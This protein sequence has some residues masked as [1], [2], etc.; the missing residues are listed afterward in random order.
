MKIWYILF[1]AV[2]STFIFTAC[3]KNDDGF[4]N[5]FGTRCDAPDSN[6]IIICKNEF[7]PGSL[8]VRKG[9]TITWRNKDGVIHTVVADN[10]I[11]FNSGNI[12]ASGSYLYHTEFTGTFNY[13]CSIHQETGVLVVSP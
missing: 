4:G 8:S 7:I 1:I 13:H 3:T 11:S 2:F 9:T 10:T 5:S 12:E 6:I